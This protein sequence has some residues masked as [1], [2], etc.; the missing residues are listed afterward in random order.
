MYRIEVASGEETVFRTIEELAVAIRNGVVTQRA[1]IYHHASEKWLPIGLHPHYKKALEMPAASVSHAPVT[2]TTPIPTPSRAKAHPPSHPKPH[3]VVQFPEPKRVLEPKPTPEPKPVLM[4]A[5]APKIPAPVQSPV[6]AMQN[7]ILRDL[8]VISIPEPLPWTVKPSPPVEP[9][10]PAHAPVVHAPVVHAPV[11]H[12]SVVHAPVVHAPVVHPLVTRAPA[13]HAPEPYRS[14]EYRPP[15]EERRDTDAD[16]LPLPRPTARRSRRMGGRPLLLLGAAAAL[17]VGTH[18]VLTATPSASADPSEPT[19][20]VAGSEEPESS[21]EP[22]SEAD[23]PA[24]GT[25]SAGTT[26]A[27]TRATEAPRVTI[28]PARVSMTPGPAFAG[29]V[30]ARPGADSTAKPKAAIQAP[31]PEPAPAA[32]SIAPAPAAIELTLPGLPPDS[33]VPTARTGDTM[34][35]KRIL[36]ALNGTKPTEASAAP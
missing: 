1:R 26:S 32:A 2:S 34:G 29:S 7:E 9:T 16:E 33:I 36:R 14:M 11:V 28:A 24:A 5:T 18:F 25:G 13:T 30:P 10:L 35:M 23:Q 19:P 4:E 6:I 3:S 12:A 22:A 20:S 21:S 8:P 15:V 17:V 31:A 27:V